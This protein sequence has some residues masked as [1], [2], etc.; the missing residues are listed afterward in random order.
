MIETRVR[1]RLSETLPV[2]RVLAWQPEDGLLWIHVAAPE[3][4]DIEYLTRGFALHPLVVEDLEHR[5]QRPKLDDYPN[6]LFIVMFGT[7][8]GP[9]EDTLILCEVHIMIGDGWLVT[10]TDAE[11]PAI[12][13]VWEAAQK[14]PEIATGTAASLFHRLCDGLVDSVFPILDSV[15]EEID[16]IENNIIERADATTVSDIFR[17]KRDLNVLRRVLGPQR[18]LLQL[19]A[20]PRTSRLD[21]DSQLYLRDVYDHTVR[22]V[23]QVDS[24]RDIV[25]GALD[26]YLTSVSNRLGE[27]TRRLTLVATIFLPLT[28]LTG[29]FGMNFGALVSAIQSPMAFAFGVSAMALATP[30]IYLVSQRLT[31]RATPTGARQGARIRRLHIRPY[32]RRRQHHEVEAAAD[33]GGNP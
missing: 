29:F 11:I 12:R 10:V 31:A 15:D 5:N 3:P 9:A 23:E 1:G 27:Q 13:Q 19:L 28:F 26:V 30:L 7:L 8:R 4:A 17:L 22:M 33:K 16:R 24:Y 6:M 32:T 20:G 14:R 21:A 25:T 2:E 18:D